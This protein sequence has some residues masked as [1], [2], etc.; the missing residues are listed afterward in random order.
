MANEIIKV[1]ELDRGYR[2]VATRD[3]EGRYGVEVRAGGGNLIA[4]TSTGCTGE[5]S[6]EYWMGNT[7]QFMQRLLLLIDARDMTYHNLLCYSKTL[8]MDTPKAG[9]ENEWELEK[10]KASMIEKWLV[11]HSNYFGKGS[12]KGADIREEFDIH[13]IFAE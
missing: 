3:D 10:D 8:A 1:K 11:D 13:E 12:S 5:K 2:V 9:Y 6:M 4:T 7:V